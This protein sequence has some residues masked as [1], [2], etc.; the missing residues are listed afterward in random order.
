MANRR[1]YEGTL[2]EITMRH[3][4]ELSG[5]RLKVTVADGPTDE[6]AKPFYETATA[7]EWSR[8]WAAWAESHPADTPLLSDEAI[9]R[10]A[11]YEGRG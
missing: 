3:G 9:S 10:D 5:R 11:I 4:G 2:E 7:E 1:I 8:A 6:G